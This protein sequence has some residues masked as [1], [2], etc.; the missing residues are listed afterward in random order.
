[1]PDHAFSNNIA[2]ARNVRRIGGL[3]DLPGG[4][5]IMV[6]GDLAYIGHMSP[7]WDT[8]IF[9]PEYFVKWLEN[10]MRASAVVVSTPRPAALIRS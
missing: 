9:M 1:M 6:R 5:Q 10:I 2:P 8:T 3:D 4:G 7:P